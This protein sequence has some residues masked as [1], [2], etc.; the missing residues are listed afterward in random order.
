MRLLQSLR[1]RAPQ[2]MIL[3]GPATAKRYLSLR[4][5]KGPLES[6]REALSF[7]KIAC[8]RALPRLW[9]GCPTFL[10]DFHHA[11]ARV[12]DH[13]PDQIAAAR[14]LPGRLLGLILRTAGQLCSRWFLRHVDFSL[15]SQQVCMRS[16]LCLAY[17]NALPAH[18]DGKRPTGAY[19]YPYVPH[20][21]ED[22]AGSIGSTEGRT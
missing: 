15:L 4:K 21:Q 9:Q 1:E 17:I 14:T 8:D 18:H 20:N 11:P 3:S 6:C 13:A 16:S 10:A 12:K 22:R 2:A 5:Y 7:Q 19:L